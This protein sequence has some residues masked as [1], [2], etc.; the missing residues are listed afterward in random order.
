M[1]LTATIHTASFSPLVPNIILLFHSNHFPL[2]Y[3]KYFP[4]KI[5]LFLLLKLLLYIFN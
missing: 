3:L 2:K 1:H 4:G 5:H